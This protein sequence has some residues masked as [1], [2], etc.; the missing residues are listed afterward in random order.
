MGKI[1]FWA[2]AD[3]STGKFHGAVIAPEEIQQS[4]WTGEN[5]VFIWDG[6]V[7]DKMPMIPSGVIKHGGKI[8]M[9]FMEFIC[10]NHRDHYEVKAYLDR[11]VGHKSRIAQGW[12]PISDSLSWDAATG[13]FGTTKDWIPAET[14][15]YYKGGTDRITVCKDDYTVSYQLEVLSEL[16]LL[17]T[18]ADE[19]ITLYK[20]R[21]KGKEYILI[22]LLPRRSKDVFNDSYMI[23]I[24]EA[25]KEFKNHRDIN[26][27]Q[28]WL[29]STEKAKS[30]LGK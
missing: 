26:V 17:N 23:A 6:L 2:K 10:S 28:D 24:P 22:H 29:Q 18:Y 27:I 16:R 1:V 25:L 19:D 7:L 13:E 14:I 5:I 4:V 11:L 15:T 3:P 20:V 30:I 9:D 21:Q 8:Y 12:E